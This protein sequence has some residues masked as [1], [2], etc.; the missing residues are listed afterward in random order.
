MFKIFRRYIFFG[1][2]LLSKAMLFLFLEYSYLFKKK[3][4]T[5][6]VKTKFKSSGA[7]SDKNIIMDTDNEEFDLDNKFFTDSDVNRLWRELSDGQTISIEYHGFKIP[8][9]NNHLKII[10]IS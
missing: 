5:I 10:T 7:F 4:K 8:F 1:L 3:Q 6:K 2:F 9:I